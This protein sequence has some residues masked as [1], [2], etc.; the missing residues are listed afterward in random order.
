MHKNDHNERPR[1]TDFAREKR[2]GEGETKL[3]AV[4]SVSPPPPPPPA[5]VAPIPGQ[6][7]TRDLLVMATPGK[8]EPAAAPPK[9]PQPQ[10]AVKGAFMRR[11]FPFLLATNVFIGGDRGHTSYSISFLY[12]LPPLHL[13]NNLLLSSL[14]IVQCYYYLL[15]YSQYAR[16]LGVLPCIDLR[17]V[18]RIL[19]S[20]RKVYFL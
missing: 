1:L 5:P 11:I 15:C 18:D 17:K 12:S 13:L 8:P 14:R 20:H 2:K 9:A 4:V 6:R 16:V 3:H 7:S 10:P 19:I